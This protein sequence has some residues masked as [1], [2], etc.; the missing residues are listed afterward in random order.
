MLNQENAKA[1]I[2]PTVK[3]CKIDDTLA[4]ELSETEFSMRMPK[5]RYMSEETE[6]EKRTR[7]WEGCL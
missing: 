3:P 1:A 6:H 2:V 4:R 5:W 7:R